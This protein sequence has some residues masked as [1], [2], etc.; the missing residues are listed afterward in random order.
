MFTDDHFQ[1]MVVVKLEFHPFYVTWHSWCTIP[2]EGLVGL[3]VS[4]VVISMVCA[5]DTRLLYGKR[6]LEG[7]GIQTIGRVTAAVFVYQIA[8]IQYRT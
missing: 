4:S 8:R 7:K 3:E 6:D 2:E 1:R 5:V